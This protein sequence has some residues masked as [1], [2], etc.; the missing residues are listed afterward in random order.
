MGWQWL[1]RDVELTL[2]KSIIKVLMLS[3]IERNAQHH[4]WN[5][6]LPGTRILIWAIKQWS[7]RPTKTDRSV[8]WVSTTVCRAHRLNSRWVERWNWRIRLILWASFNLNHFL[9]FLWFHSVFDDL[10]FDFWQIWFHIVTFIH[11]LFSYDFMTFW[12]HAF[13]ASLCHS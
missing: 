8:V 13:F 4:R 12:S 7:L 3:L 1:E 2:N 9:Q 6:I 11:I 10:I 5:F